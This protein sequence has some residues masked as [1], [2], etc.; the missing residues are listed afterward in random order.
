MVRALDLTETRCEEMSAQVRTLTQRVSTIERKRRIAPLLDSHA[1]LCDELE[2]LSETP[3]L[4]PDA[5]ERRAGADSRLRAAET[6]HRR[7]QAVV[8][9]LDRKL[10]TI[11]VDEDAIARAD[12]IRTLHDLVSVVRK[13]AEDRRKR[14]SELT[15][16]EAAL[17]RA[18]AT[19][20]VEPGAVHELR[21]PATAKRA[22]DGCLRDHAELVERKRA[23]TER[24]NDA[25]SDLADDRAALE[26]ADP[27][28]D[29]ER[30]RAAVKAAAKLGPVTSQ[31]ADARAEEERLRS[32]A[33]AAMARLRSG[34]TTVE[35]LRR[36]ATPS[37][38]AVQSAVAAQQGLMETHA[39]LCA[40]RERIDTEAAQ[41][42]EDRERLQLAGSAPTSDELGLAR[43]ER[44]RHWSDLRA[45]IENEAPPSP[46][47]VDEF[48]HAVATADSV[49]DAR[50]T[51]AA[52]IEQAA[53]IEA[54]HRRLARD[55]EQLSEKAR[56][57]ES[58]GCE[59]TEAW[60]A[61]WAETG[62]RPPAPSEAIGWLDE[63][64]KVLAFATSAA[65]SESRAVALERQSS[66]HQASIAVALSDL[67]A[68]FGDGAGLGELVEISE[69]RVAE[70]EARSLESERLQTAIARSDRLLTRARSEMEQVTAALQA[71][72]HAW[73]TRQEEAGLPSDATP[74]AAPEITRAVGEALAHI[75]T[76]GDLARRIAGIDRDQAEFDRR[77]AGL[78]RDLASELEGL[79][80]ERAASALMTRL[81][82]AEADAA[83]RANLRDQRDNS[84]RQ[85]DEAKGELDGAA[86]ELRGLVDDA[87]CKDISELPEVERCAARVR[88]LRSEIAAVERQVKQV[89]EAR[90]E[91]LAAET[92]GFDRDTADLEMARLS[93]QIEQL[94][95]ERDDLNIEIGEQ[96]Q[97]LV[98]AEKSIDA[99]TAA[100]DLEL[101]RSRI[102]ELARKHAQAKLSARIVRRAM[103]RYREQHEGPLLRR[104][105]ELFT[106]FTRGSFVQVF[107]DHDDRAGAVLMGRQRDRKLIGVPEMSD[108]TREQL[109]L[110]LR[111][112][113]IERYIATSGP[114]PVL[115]DDVF[116]ESDE[117]RSERIF[118]AL[119]ELALRTQVIVLTHHEH[120]IPL[121]QKV[122]ADKLAV[123]RLADT[124]PALR[125][126]P[127]DGQDA[128]VA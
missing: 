20:G 124:A 1:A 114:V 24:V 67:G 34:P 63:R 106:R 115:F 109:F 99:V 14:D 80:A 71:W 105:N 49:A 17:D 101:A 58:A 76:I 15:E 28:P 60:A 65:Q 91:Q 13:A 11:E 77:L 89:G 37:R 54:R 98:E 26:H 95:T 110:A 84:L 127:V 126:A 42:A 30:L 29:I 4:A 113:A 2:G 123:H 121:G 86:S 53:R 25:E 73:P 119:G 21:R 62:L 75:D 6:A 112:A 72:D 43:A 47:V 96:R 68:T 31:I 74:D 46:G 18:A 59:A 70:A 48:E 66:S 35:D 88:E 22:L 125:P 104:A 102:L 78:C 103:E 5:P 69:R 51:G 118:E 82:A 3:D 44:D 93:G 85:V 79:A 45:S 64:E 27:P 55:G 7:A 39:T 128:L 120:L 19:I 9:Q 8:D 61:M 97:R 122:L 32:E 108:G 57:N 107:V 10:A 33:E 100:Q 87:S 111:I 81:T 12:E 23:A 38:E 116:L 90:F 16:A 94:A 41:L 40:E 36:M 50:T 92:T 56:E 83:R 117:P 52:Q